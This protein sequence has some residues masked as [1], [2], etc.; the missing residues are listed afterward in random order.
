MTAKLFGAAE[1][2]NRMIRLAA[3]G[4]PVQMEVNI[5]AR[6]HEQDATS[7]NVIAEI[8]GTDL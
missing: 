2:Y 7:H 3:R 8:P 6:F 4:V 5:D 1:Q